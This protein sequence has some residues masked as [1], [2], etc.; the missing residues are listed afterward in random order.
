MGNAQTKRISPPPHPDKW[1]P[2]CELA[3][4]SSSST[5]PARPR[6]SYRGGTKMKIKGT[7]L[8][9]G[10]LPNPY[11]SVTVPAA[12]KAATP[13]ERAAVF[14]DSGVCLVDAGDEGEEDLYRPSWT[15]WAYVPRIIITPPTPV[16][17]ACH[18]SSSP[19]R[20]HHHHRCHCNRIKNHGVESRG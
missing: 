20:Y 5:S 19:H 18:C 3:P 10:S 7:V 6:A 8:I 15:D 1:T 2:K 12:A 4:S 16:L 11:P 17:A 9:G 14:T 13:S